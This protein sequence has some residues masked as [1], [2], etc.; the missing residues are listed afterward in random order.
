[1]IYFNIALFSS[2]LPSL[3]FVGNYWR[4][5][6]HVKKFFDTLASRKGFDPLMVENWY[7]YTKTELRKEEV[8]NFCI[9]SCVY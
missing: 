2:Y 5:R 7:K 3:L 6:A 1:L 8:R 4:N 9:F